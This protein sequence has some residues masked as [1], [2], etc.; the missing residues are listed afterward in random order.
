MLL[1]QEAACERSGVPSS[2]T[3]A[4]CHSFAASPLSL[5]PAL[6]KATYLL[7][8]STLSAQPLTAPSPIDPATSI[9]FSAADWAKIVET[10]QSEGAAVKEVVFAVKG[11]EP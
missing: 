11:A 7:T 10:L 3:D 6:A 5:P 2:Y 9:T 8:S 1:I 4:V